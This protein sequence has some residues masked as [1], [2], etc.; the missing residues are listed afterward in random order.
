MAPSFMGCARGFTPGIHRSNLAI[1]YIVESAVVSFP[2]PNAASGIGSGNETKSAG[3][4]ANITRYHC[5]LSQHVFLTFCHSSF[6]G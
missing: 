5:L 2:D 1:S 6:A 4:R 3:G